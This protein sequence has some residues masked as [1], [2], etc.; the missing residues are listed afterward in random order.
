MLDGEVARGAGAQARRGADDIAEAGVAGDLKRDLDVGIGGIGRGDA[1]PEDGRMPVGI[2]GRHAMQEGDRRGLS[3]V[4]QSGAG[5]GARSDQAQKA[6][7][8]DGHGG[9]RGT[10]KRTA[11]RTDRDAEEGRSQYLMVR[12]TP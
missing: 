5:D 12:A 1:G 2:A 4:G 8:I 11:S 10:Q 6:A 9:L 3:G 7:T